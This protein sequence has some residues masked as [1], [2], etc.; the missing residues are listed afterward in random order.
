[1]VFLQQGQSGAKSVRTPMPSS[2]SPCTSDHVAGECGVCLIV[3]DEFA[4][5]KACGTPSV[6]PAKLCALPN[7]QV[8]GTRA[9][10]RAIYDLLVFSDCVCARGNPTCSVAAFE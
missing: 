7:L 2:P 1:M 4:V 10:V 8:Y 5:R 3:C 9:V 6:L